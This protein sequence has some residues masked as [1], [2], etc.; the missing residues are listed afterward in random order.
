MDNPKGS[1]PPHTPVSGDEMEPKTIIHKLRVIA[2]VGLFGALVGGSIP[3]S[4][5]L[6]FGMAAATLEEIGL[7]LGVVAGAVLV[8]RKPNF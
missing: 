7:T 6:P 5:L 4:L 1:P 3:G 8:Y 2:S